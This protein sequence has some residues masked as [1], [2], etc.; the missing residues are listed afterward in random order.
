[1]KQV[2]PLFLGLV[3]SL[4]L[5]SS[6][7]ISESVLWDLLIDVSLEKNPIQVFENP[8]VNG[9]IVDHAGK[10]VSSA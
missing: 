3:L 2:E 10:P 4:L 5:F 1:M 8:I 7:Q 6:F 9:T